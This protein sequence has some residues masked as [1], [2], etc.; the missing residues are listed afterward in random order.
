[1][2]SGHFLVRNALD[3]RAF[4]VAGGAPDKVAAY[5]TDHTVAP[6]DIAKTV[7]HVMGVEDLQ[8]IDREGRSFDLL[9]EGRAPTELL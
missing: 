8:A 9:P 4:V 7:Y 3:R 6:E 5:P 2:H 1:M